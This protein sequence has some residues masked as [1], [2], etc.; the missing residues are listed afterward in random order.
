MLFVLLSLVMGRETIKVW[1]LSWT[2]VGLV[3]LIFA[4]GVFYWANQTWFAQVG[5]YQWYLTWRSS[6][7]LQVLFASMPEWL[8][9]PF[10][11]VYGVF[12]PLLPAALIARSAAPLWQAVAIWRSLGW[13]V[14]LV[15][16]IYA[17]YLSLRKGNW[18]KTPG[19]L[20]LMSWIFTFVASYRGGGDDWD[21]P[22][23][24]VSIAGIQ[25]ILAAWALVTRREEKDP[26]L[27]R[28]I[29]IAAAITLWMLLWYLPRYFAVPWEMW[30]PLDA[31]GLGLVSCVLYLIW[32]LCRGKS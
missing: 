21:N 14:L 3:L 7:H 12:R 8:Q 16:L 5:Y 18:Y 4:A 28:I 30:K 32:D 11:V 17:S 19:A 20:L 31:L 24:R 6:G 27:R 10:V 29:G 9:L 25:V 15:L 26:W 1:K 2:V 23:Y 13:M 22:R